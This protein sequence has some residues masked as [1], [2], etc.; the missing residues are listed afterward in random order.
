MH[1]MGKF[2]S[3]EFNIL[4][5]FLSVFRCYYIKKQSMDDQLSQLDA[6]DPEQ[7]VHIYTRSCQSRNQYFETKQFSFYVKYSARPTSNVQIRNA[8]LQTSVRYRN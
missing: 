7:S 6:F 2:L 3:K 4:Y 8:N 1:L 5:G